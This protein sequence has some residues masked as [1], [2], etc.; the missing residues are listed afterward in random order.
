MN[1]SRGGADVIIVL[2]LLA[3]AAWVISIV[4][5]VMMY[6][7][8]G[9]AALATFIAFFWTLVCL[10]A[11]RNGL[12]VGRIWIDPDH[13]RA[14]IIRGLFGAFSVPAFL[15]LADTLTD[16]TIAWEYFTYYV[17]GGYTAFSV[18]V[19]YMIVRAEGAAAILD[20]PRL[21]HRHANNQELLPPPSQK[22][23]PRYASWDDDEELGA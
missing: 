19:E 7:A 8:L 10:L 18:G 14:F 16:L 17:I 2:I 1:S 22:R 6:V 4:V 9:L 15:L 12:G 23:L 11:W 13:A 5:M 20:A 3:V 21:S